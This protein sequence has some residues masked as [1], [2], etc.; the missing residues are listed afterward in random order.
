MSWLLFRRVLPP[1]VWRG[2]F[3]LTLTLPRGASAGTVASEQG[4]EGSMGRAAFGA[5]LM[6]TAAAVLSAAAM[7]I[8]VQ[9]DRA[10]DFSTVHTYAWHPDGAGRVVAMT[11]SQDDPE[12]IRRQ[13]EPVIVGA[14]ERELAR[15]G[16]TPAPASSRPD[17]N[18]SY[19]LLISAG[20]TATDMF[21]DFTLPG[22]GLP[23]ISRSTNYLKVVERGSLVVDLAATSEDA[24]VWRGVA[25]AEVNRQKTDEQ[26]AARIQEAVRKMLEQYPPKTGKR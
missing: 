24:V 17:V 23:P 6:V 15:R 2:E 26:R 20:T 5:I 25:E 16:F 9:F 19:Y 3:H 21:A 8:H 10:F 14:V 18:V 12:A 1:P 11:S 4:I 22:W 13:L 7:K